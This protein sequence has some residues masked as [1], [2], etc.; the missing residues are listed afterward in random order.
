[1]EIAGDEGIVY[2]TVDWWNFL[3]DFKKS[4][5]L[6]VRSLILK[7]KFEVYLGWVSYKDIK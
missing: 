6:L 7:N 2:S 3:R 1:M 5:L 4:G